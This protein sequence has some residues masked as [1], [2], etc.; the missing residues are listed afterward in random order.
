MKISELIAELKKAKKSY[1]DLPVSAFKGGAFHRPVS[2][3]SA[4]YEDEIHDEKPVQ[5]LII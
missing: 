2:G 1:G 3:L 4:E 5:I